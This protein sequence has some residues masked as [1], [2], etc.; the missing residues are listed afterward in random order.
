[1]DINNDRDCNLILD[2]II[3][4]RRSTRFFNDEVPSKKDIESILNAGMHAPYAAQA[5]GD[6]EYFR[7]FFVFENGSPK[8]ETAGRLMGKKAEEGLNHFKRMITEKPFLKARVHPFMEKLQMI[9]DKGVLGV[10]TA[11][12]FIV[13][14]ELRG[15]PPVEQESIAHCL[16]NMWLKSTA[17]KIGFHLVS[18]TSQMA[19]DE[20][21]LKLLDIPHGKYGLNGCAVGY[22]T[23]KTP[24]VPRPDTIKA[25]KWMDNE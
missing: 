9:V 24:I 8:M 20:E 15:V 22:P 2:S 14:A 16:E 23:I 6:N 7:R 3:E 18:L 13:V 5:V 19:E 10:G 11:P 4:S 12:Y 17:L 1:M 25:T 21:F